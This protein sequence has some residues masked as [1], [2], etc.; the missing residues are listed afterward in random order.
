MLKQQLVVWVV[1]A[2]A[3]AITTALFI[4]AAHVL[5]TPDEKS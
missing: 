4:I 1:M 2:I 5:L 3:I